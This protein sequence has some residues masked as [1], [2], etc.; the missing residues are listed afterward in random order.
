MP[1]LDTALIYLLFA[2]IGV[3][4]CRLLHLP[5]MLGYLVAGIFLA[6]GG[7]M[8]EANEVAVA[9]V[10]EIGV[11]LL[12]FVIGLEFN[13]PKL[14]GMRRMVF[15][16]GMAQVVLMLAGTLIGHF[17][18]ANILASFNLPWDLNWQGAVVLGAALAMSSTAI[19]VKMMAERA[20]LDS[21]HGRR[22]IGAL[23]FQDLAV[24]PLLV[25]I[26]ALGRMNEGNV[27]AELSLALLKAAVLVG[28][29]LW[30]GQKAMRVWLRIVDRRN[31]EELFM[32]NIL[33]ITL[34]LAWLTEHAGLSMAMGS[35]MAGMLI[36][37]TDYKH[38]VE[39]DIRPFHDVFLG[40][41][42]ITLGMKLDWHV[43]QE[44]WPW[45]L[46]LTL[47][48]VL[49]KAVLIAVLA[50]T[51]GASNGVAARTGIY[52]A[53]AGEFGFV[54]LTLGLAQGLIDPRWSNPVLAAMVLSML[55][56]PF[57]IQHA[58][59]WVFR[60]S[61]DD[62]LSQS[63]QITTIASHAIAIDKHVL[64]C[65]FGHTGRNLCQLLAQQKISYIALDVNPEVVK[66]AVLD[67]HHVE[68]GDSFQ[69][70]NLV[71]AGLNRASA[72]VVSF[73]DTVTALGVISLVHKHAPSVPVLVRTRDE[74]DMV[75][76]KQAGAHEVIP[77]AFEVSL[78]LA[79]HTM[80][81][82]GVEEEKINQ[83]VFIQR[84]TQ[85]AGLKETA[86]LGS[87]KP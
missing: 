71:S 61:P 41:F 8:V 54:L 37:E 51:G 6:Q 62:W 50:Y 31:S 39:E 22:V 73:D 69:L 28:L 2:V 48:P 49:V 56:T 81:L 66:T 45:V 13:L 77:D 9:S 60:F 53:Q 78:S 46:V 12:M 29:L 35:F 59:R 80:S 27:W 3:V 67:G 26:P 70:S 18:I 1:T 58:D 32:L 52:L 5:A 40:L 63:L 55:A 82:L 24:V 65:G 21:Q 57:L 44:Q 75:L 83:L 7:A 23:L 84:H 25:L 36:A 17:L 38:R 47:I 86:I 34:G 15:G 42:F 76:L 4:G 14:M 79:T 19:V 74:H 20:E 68:V 33:L 16:F 30:G 64:V 85:Y 43:L 87:E 72:V 10:A 11:V